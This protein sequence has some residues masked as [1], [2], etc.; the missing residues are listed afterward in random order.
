MAVLVSRTVPADRVRAGP[1]REARTV[2]GARRAKAP[3]RGRA[4]ARVRAGS[5]PRL[6]APADLATKVHKP[7]KVVKVVSRAPGA[8]GAA[9]GVPL[10]P[11]GLRAEAATRVPHRS[12][13]KGVEGAAE[14]REGA[15]SAPW[16][17]S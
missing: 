6:R 12:P 16:L 17:Q 13:L 1:A 10:A 9:H 7:A 3:T 5:S 8:L 2:R 4:A 11:Q 15:L 14:A